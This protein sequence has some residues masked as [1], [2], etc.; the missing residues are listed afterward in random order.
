MFDSLDNFE[1][2]PAGTLITAPVG[3]GKTE[4]AIREILLEREFRPFSAIWVLLAN[5]QQIHSFRE[6]LLAAS[7][8]AVQFGVEFFD[9]DDLYARLLDLLNNPQRQVDE[10]SRYQI[11]RHVTDQL[12]AR[13]ELEYFGE[14]AH[15]SGFIGLVAGLL[16]E[17]KQGL[18]TPEDFARVT[19]ARGPKDRDLYRIYEA[20]QSFLQAKML[21]DRHG[22]GWLVIEALEAEKSAPLPAVDLL[23]IDGF[24]QFNALQAR[25]ITRLAQRVKRTILTLTDA[26]GRRFRRFEQT[27]ERVLKTAPD[28]WQVGEGLQTL[29]GEA[30]APRSASLDHLVESI[31]IGSAAKVPSNDALHLIEAPDPGRE[32]RAVLRRIKRLLLAGKSPESMAIITRGISRYSNTLR[33]A[34]RAY[35]VPLAVRDG[36]ALRD[37]PVIALIL[38]LIDL[39]A[40]DFP[41][42][43]LLDTLR[44]PYLAAPDLTADQIALLEHLSSERQIVRGRAAWFAALEDAAHVWAD[45]DREDR[46]AA[47]LAAPDDRADLAESLA[48]QL[49]RITP[50]EQATV[51]EFVRWLERLIGPDPEA[52]AHDAAETGDLPVGAEVAARESAAVAAEVGDSAGDAAN[53]SAA[54]GEAAHFDVMGRVRATPEAEHVT[55][56]LAALKKFKGVL[57]GIRAAHDLLAENGDPAL[58][59]W[60]NFRAELELALDRANITPPDSLS[61][62]GRVI[63]TDVLHVRGLPHDHVFIL[64]LS[65]GVFPAQ[66]TG[67]ALY[68]EAERADLERAGI[69]MLT[70]IERTDDMSLFYEAL[71]LAR[72]T[73]TLTRFTVDDRGAPCPPS[74][75]WRAV[76][77]VIDVPDDQI[78][79]I[80]VGSS[81][82]LID[83]AT[84]T[85]TAVAITAIYTGEHEAG[86]L[87][88]VSVHNALLDQTDYAPRW[89]NV[90]RGRALEARREDPAQP[91]D[92]H[93]GLLTDP[94]LIRAAADQLG[95]ERVWSA[96]Q[97]NEYGVCPFRFFARRL[98][99]LE[100]LAEPEEGL[101]ALQLGSINHAILEVAYRA[102]ADDGLTITP[103]NTDRALALLDAAA[104]RVFATA[105]RAYGF[106]PSPVWD[107]EQAEMLRR[108]RW[109]VTLD[110]ASDHDDNPFRPV[111]SR[112]N[113]PVAQMIQD[114]TR[115]PF[116]Q[117]AA[118]GLNDQPPLEIDGPAGTLKVRGVIDRLDRAGDYLVVMDYKSGTTPHPVKDMIAGR[119]FQMLVYLLAARERIARSDPA[120]TVIGGL[121]WHIRSRATSGEILSADAALDEA[122][123]RLHDNVRAARAGW[124]AVKPNQ[125]RGGQCSAYCEFRALCRLNR[126]HDG[127]A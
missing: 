92:Q 79:R 14:I 41:R 96:S 119:D 43:D 67:I 37:S 11:L 49:D 95:P 100:E 83:A 10:T 102:I 18:V 75:Y 103:E 30:I 112:Q 61:R 47:S 77:A 71:G 59:D 94:D 89:L 66:E 23:V 97:F 3:A 5:R 25:L 9:V 81:P 68:Q 52:N 65:E 114:V 115:I 7:A 15:Y 108:L 26:P 21:V 91:F 88:P 17:L 19:A 36:I 72:Q 32:V 62:L 16:H 1:M 105:P 87:D 45:E 74:P 63:A 40:L 125:T 84:I 33:E 121:F 106:R 118:F 39:A 98:L 4:Y 12:R 50:P 38:S 123:I 111:T 57:R 122:L 20:Y 104:K 86:D 42:R 44:S 107:H 48:R 78:E 27:R 55:R 116:W 22:A 117:E 64:G 2:P 58:V 90:L 110:F 113:R 51:Y 127:K 13:G 53:R 24:D 70:A 109:L 28:F 99:K 76:Q 101:D 80:G 34:A 120:L 6:R 73:L 35:G 82:R 54:A 60:A 93:T 29:P 46:R 124:F 56:D 85:E 69:D 31:F 8:D 126:A